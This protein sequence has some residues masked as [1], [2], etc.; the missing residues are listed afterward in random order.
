[1][2]P[3]LRS[4]AAN[5]GRSAGHIFFGQLIR[6]LKDNL[7]GWIN[8]CGITRVRGSTGQGVS[9]QRKERYDCHLR[10]FDQVHPLTC[11]RSGLECWVMALWER[12]T[13]MRFASCLTSFGHRPPSRALLPSAGA[14]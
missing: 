4:I 10:D 14:T 9:K 8:N 7:K 1:M 12:R 2:K 6:E 13:P 11:P 5:V 3:L